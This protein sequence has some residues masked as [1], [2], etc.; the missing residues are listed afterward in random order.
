MDTFRTPIKISPSR[1]KIRYSDGLLFLGSCFT[2]YIG[3]RLLDLH[4]NASINPS[5]VLFNPSSIALTLRRIHSGELYHE[6]ELGFYRDLWFSYDHHT[7]FS[8]PDKA[9]CL[10]K[11]NREAGK[12][13]LHL[14]QSRFLIVTFGTAWVY[15]L[16]ETGKIVANCHK[17]PASHFERILLRPEEIIKDF[18][19]LILELRKEHPELQVIFTV[20]PVRHLGDGMQENQLSKSILILAANELASCMK[21]CHYFPAFEIMMDD[22]RDYRFYEPDLVHPNQLAIDYI[23][24]AFTETFMDTETI[25]ITREVDKLR[26]ASLHR[27]LHPGGKEYRIFCEAQLKHMASLKKHY[28]FLDLSAEEAC[29]TAGL[30]NL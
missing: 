8:H 4:F 9:A 29:F 25:A 6:N 11:I 2:G 28:P 27:P 7:S 24:N 3:S 10:E 17:W 18:T 26:K 16:T 30:S 14:G 19:G 13:H 1:E 21:S 15:R 20:S 23:W 5:G 22:L 12:A